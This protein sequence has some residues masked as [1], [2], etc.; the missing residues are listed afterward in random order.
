MDVKIHT[1]ETAPEP[2]KP[3]L[4]ASL[5]KFKFI[6]N[7]HGVMAEAP[8]L[9]EAYQT[10]SALWAK[11]GLSVVERQLV[12]LAINHENEC[13]YCMAAHSGIATMEKMPEEIL[14]ALREGQPVPDA[15]L[16]AL[17]R[18]AVKVV[19]ERGWVSDADLQAVLDAGYTRQTVY[20]VV[21][22]V[23]YKTLSNYM[24]H[25]AETPVDEPFRQFLWEP[26]AKAAAE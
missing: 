16:E 3:L 13:H 9:L 23:G 22:A 10:L 7:L 19:R 4:Q 24:N 26:K 18:F 25:I 12:L 6:P 20:E 14:T 1:V 5:D 8:A 17:R 11:T 2:A 21:L 15:K